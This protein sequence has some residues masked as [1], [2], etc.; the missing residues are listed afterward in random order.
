MVEHHSILWHPINALLIR[1]LG[2]PPVEKLSPGMAHFFFPN[3]KEAWLPDAAIMALLL[4]TLIAILFPLAAKKFNRYGP[5]GVQNFLEMLVS[6]L[7]GLV[8]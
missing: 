3:G 7:R 2:V 5:G 1:L 4:M 8:A 6:F